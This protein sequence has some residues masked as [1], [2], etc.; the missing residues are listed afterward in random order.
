YHWKD[1]SPEEQRP[2]LARQLDLARRL[3][4]PVIFHCR[5]ALEDLFGVLEAERELPPGVFH[6][7]S[8]GPADA[9]RA[10]GLGFHLSFAGNV[11]FPKALD[12]Q[13]AL[14]EVPLERLLLETDC[15]YLAPQPVRGR[16]NEPAFV[17]HTRDFIARMKGVA[18]EEVERATD[19]AARGLFNIGGLT[20]FR[21]P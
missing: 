10:L 16:R 17:R 7:F 20:P 14:S 8:G 5:K 11:T 21:S 3:G 4:L 2:R 6:C 13:A 18:P 19:Q 9:R 12:L 1:V 15:P